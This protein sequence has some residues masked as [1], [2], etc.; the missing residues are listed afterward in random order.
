MLPVWNLSDLYTGTDDP[1]VASDLKRLKTGCCDFA[2]RFKGKTALLEPAEFGQALQFYEALCELDGRL[3]SYA[4]LLQAE[5]ISDEHS[6]RFAQEIREKS[7][8]AGAEILFFP[9]ETAALNDLETARL[10]SDETVARYRPYLENLR[11]YRPHNLNQDVEQILMEKDTV[12][13]SAFVRVFDETMAAV[14]VPIRDE[15]L[16]LTQA[17]NLFNS[18]DRE[19]RREAGAA[20]AAELNARLPLITLTY[21][22]LVK[23]KQLEDKWRRYETPASFRHLSNR[24]EPEVVEAMT[25][26]VRESYASTAH[27]YY[28]L[29]AKWLKL[30]R[31]EHFDRNAPAFPHVRERTYTWDEAVETVSGAYRGFSETFYE[32]ALPFFEQG[33]IDAAPRPGKAQGAFAHSTVPSVHPYLLMSFLG[34]TRDVMTLAH[35]LGHGIHQRLSARQGYLM[36]HSPLTFAETASVFG[37]MLTFR[38]LLDQEK[39]PEIRRML[40]AQKVEDMINTVVRQTAFHQ[41]ETTV[42]NERRNGELSSGRLA[43]IWHTV[44]QE[45]LGDAFRFTPEYDPYWSYISHFF[46]SPFYVYAYAFGDCLVNALYTVYQE[47]DDK[48]GFVEKYTHMLTLGGTQTHR[49]MLAPF[50]LDAT[51]RNFWKK[52]LKVL[53]DFIDEL[54]E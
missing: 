36:A 3:S 34:K 26:A 2:R 17:L 19:L 54:E 9:L 25:G 11:L 39:D 31:L 14:S 21:N 6:A 49:D 32:T 1:R 18:A 13:N 12:S 5:N 22:T 29:K 40:T 20:T 7:A 42:H 33:W 28:R 8:E 44:Q 27:R 4:Q 43:E 38:A 51:D 52:G 24:L 50:G 37:E 23:D 46:H 10:L 30:D 41:F 47:T 53:E 45:S 48:A 35:E 15:K 16:T